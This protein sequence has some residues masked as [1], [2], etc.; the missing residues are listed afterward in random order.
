MN[1]LSAVQLL[2]SAVGWVAFA[3]KLRDLRRAPRNPMRRA[4]CATLFLASACVFCGAPAVIEAVNR[5]TGV[6]NF[7]APLVYC[8]LVAL[9]ASCHV[10]MAYWRL[11]A[12]EARP[13]A[14]RWTLAYAA[15]VVTLIALFV[16]GD[17]SVE[18]PVNFD[19][20]YA[21]TPYIAQFVLLYLVALNV[22]MVSLMRMCW[23]WAKVAGRPWLRRGLRLIVLGALGAFGFGVAKLTAVAARWTGTD[24]DGLD[25]VLAPALAMVGL[26]VSAVGYALPALGDHLS[27]LRGRIGR[28]RAYRALYPLWDA[29]RRATPAIVPPARV[30]W[31]DFEL[32]LTR[33]LAEI[34]DGRLALRSHCDPEVARTA[35]R[36]GREA[37][38]TGA[39]LHAAVD[40]AR[41][42]AAVAAKAENV[43][44]PQE[45]PGEESAAGDGGA[46]GGTDAIG[47]LAW[48]VGVSRAFA[49]SPVVAAAVDR[50]GRPAGTA[51]S[52]RG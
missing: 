8:L 23:G 6:P 18:K 32:R 37:G 34:N 5:L 30:P 52:A 25:S 16:V 2:C 10:L 13:V 20:H 28:Y 41:L 33:R 51:R 4:V 15:V 3:V 35:L 14:R 31:W 42:K 45:D 46:R 44:F 26:V 7:S 11:S 1:D 27:V 29:L 49:A 9:G 36:L 47:E 50:T 48:L 38:L 21:T 24:W 43:R 19:T 12:E 39:E 17:A 22:A 40:A